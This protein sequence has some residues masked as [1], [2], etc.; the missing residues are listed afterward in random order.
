MRRPQPGLGALLL[1]ACTRPD[2][3]PAA[4][5]LAAAPPIAAP[6]LDD[7]GDGFLD[8]VDR[9]RADPGVEP[10]GCPY[11]DS[12]GDGL[13]DRDDR[14][15]TR[16]ETVNGIADDDGCPEALPPNGCPRIDGSPPAA[17]FGPAA[18]PPAA[19]RPLLAALPDVARLADPGVTVLPYSPD[20]RGFLTDAKINI[21]L[22][23]DDTDFRNL[24][25][26]VAASGFMDDD[27]DPA[28][29]VQ[30]AG[31][32]E[33][34]APASPLTVEFGPCPWRP[35]HR[36]ARVRVQAPAAPASA[37]LELELITN[38]AALRSLRWL[39]GD[40]PHVLCDGP[41]IARTGELA[42]GA[43]V[44]VLLE[45]D[46]AATRD[47]LATL[48]LRAGDG[49][50]I[51]QLDLLD[52]HRDAPSLAMQVAR[53]AAELALLTRRSEPW[54]ALPDVFSSRGG[55]RIAALEREAAALVPRDPTGTVARL[56]AVLVGLRR[57]APTARRHA[58][59]V[60][61]HFTRDP[62]DASDRAEVRDYTEAE[63]RARTANY[64]ELA[65]RLTA[66]GT[67]H[68]DIF[69]RLS[70]RTPPE[71]RWE[72]VAHC[73]D[74]ELA[75][76]AACTA[77]ATRRGEVVRERLIARGVD[78]SLLSIRPATADER[79]PQ[80]A[81]ARMRA[82]QRRVDFTPVRR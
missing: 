11:P 43:V 75:D 19:L 2:A 41:R 58:L 35:R 56:H 70:R 22:S 21:P 77:I 27:L 76:P 54:P 29:L 46:A 57:V 74:R 50:P 4:P 32:L 63:R 17:R 31:A 73:D 23:P 61:A 38:P 42:P 33:P 8:S 72:L 37:P 69:V 28:E 39:G 59:A 81:D 40:D 6:E 26:L 52:D 44:T 78:P 1:L 47:P 48:A 67:L 25:R 14:C 3:P 82:D 34:S 68:A 66:V 62:N 65:T 9:C 15:V 5:V 64:F 49:P 16:R 20:A 13:L 45:L 12:D 10:D 60:R 30:L 51:Q 79:D 71:L 55:R 80:A 53:I 36:L 18:P 24:E 7:D